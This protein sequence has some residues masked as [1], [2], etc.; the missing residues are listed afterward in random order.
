V[1]SDENPPSS[2][3]DCQQ[4]RRKATAVCAAINRYKQH[5]V[6]PPA[7]LWALISHLTLCGNCKAVIPSLARNYRGFL[8]DRE[9]NLLHSV[10]RVV[11]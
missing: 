6:M 5:S 1:M 11:E 2:E 10:F 8:T 4:V 7:N 9:A 3:V